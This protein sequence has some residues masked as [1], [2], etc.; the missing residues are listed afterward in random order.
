MKKSTTTKS[1]RTPDKNRSIPTI[2]A[3]KCKSWPTQ[4][5]R[6]QQ[7]K[8]TANLHII[9]M[10]R[11]IL[12]A[13]HNGAKFWQSKP[14]LCKHFNQRRFCYA[15]RTILVDDVGIE[16][17]NGGAS[18]Q[19]KGINHGWSASNNTSFE[20]C[21]NYISQSFWNQKDNLEQRTLIMALRLTCMW[22]HLKNS[23]RVET[24]DPN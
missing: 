2:L 17:E 6:R 8:S 19:L 3:I 10:S 20:P 16:R 13:D 5:L 4:T 9:I 21:T 14:A 23:Q 15:R 1:G 22:T 24:M 11:S 12:K 18:R 7:G